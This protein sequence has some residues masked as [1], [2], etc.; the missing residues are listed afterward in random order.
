[1]RLPFALASGLRGQYAEIVFND[2]HRF[3]TGQ[4]PTAYGP[5]PIF[6]FSDGTSFGGGAGVSIFN[7]S[8]PIYVTSPSSIVL[9][10]GGS[11]QNVVTL[12]GTYFSLDP[13][14]KIT[15]ICPDGPGI[16]VAYAAR[17]VN[18]F[19]GANFHCNVPHAAS[20][21]L[22]YQIAYEALNNLQPGRKVYVE[23]TNE[24]WNFF[25]DAFSALSAM[26][27]MVY[28]GVV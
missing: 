17:V 15:E 16:P 14:C 28:P 8:L 12:S 1:N 6:Q 26:S 4:T 2:Q 13:T 10:C 23:Y 20:D 21:S 5:W 24:P 27:R 9:Q 22:I 7:Y 3:N 18:H 25:F 19:P 11:S